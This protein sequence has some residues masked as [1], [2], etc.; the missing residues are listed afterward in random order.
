MVEMESKLECRINISYQCTFVDAA[1]FKISHQFSNND[2]EVY[3]ED[4]KFN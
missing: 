4:F 2:Q 1:Q 3:D